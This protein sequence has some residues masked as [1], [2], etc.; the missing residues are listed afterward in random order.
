MRQRRAALRFQKDSPSSNVVVEPTRLER[1]IV[2]SYARIALLKSV[3]SAPN[4]LCSG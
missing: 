1:F 3:R 4:L 2:T